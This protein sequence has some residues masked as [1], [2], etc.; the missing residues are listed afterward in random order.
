MPLLL[1]LRFGLTKKFAGPGQPAPISIL[2]NLKEFWKFPP[3][4]GLSPI[5]VRQASMNCGLGLDQPT[6]GSEQ[7]Q[8]PLTG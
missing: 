2:G 8:L 3:T 4:P 6:G 1:L 7:K 5:L